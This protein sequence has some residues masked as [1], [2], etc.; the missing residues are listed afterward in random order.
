MASV[1]FNSF[2]IRQHDHAV[3]FSHQDLWS[4][5]SHD[6][7]ER[8]AC[9]RHVSKSKTFD[10]RLTSVFFGGY[11]ITHRRQ[12]NTRDQGSPAYIVPALIKWEGLQ[13]LKKNEKLHGQIAALVLLTWSAIGFAHEVCATE[14]DR[15][16]GKI[17]EIRNHCKCLFV[18]GF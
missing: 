18:F 9:K 4:I 15:P 14:R 10:F 11:L 5:I 16:T 1:V 2:H 6:E 3:S 12:I 8:P 17:S 7:R 13:R